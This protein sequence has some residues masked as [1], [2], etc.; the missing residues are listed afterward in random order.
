MKVHSFCEILVKLPQHSEEKKFVLVL[1]IHDRP[2]DIMIVTI[3]HGDNAI[4]E[5]QCGKLYISS[6]HVFGDF[7]EHYASRL[8]YKTM[9]TWTLDQLPVNVSLP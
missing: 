5:Q 6:V 2:K 7:T 3:L 8:L 1:L 4:M 9:V